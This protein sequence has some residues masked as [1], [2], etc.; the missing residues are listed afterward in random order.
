MLFQQWFSFL[1]ALLD[2]VAVVVDPVSVNLLV[3]VVN[4]NGCSRDSVDPQLLR[5]HL[6]H[7]KMKVEVFAQLIS[8][9]HPFQSDLSVQL[10]VVV[11]LMVMR[12]SCLRSPHQIPHQVLE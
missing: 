3:L 11:Q 1:S 12:D 10:M 6:R 5:L 2:R 7:V 4:L 8:I 9:I